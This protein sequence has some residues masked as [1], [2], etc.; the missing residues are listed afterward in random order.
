VLLAKAGVPYALI[1]DLD[2][3]N[4]E[5]PTADVAIVTGANDVVDPAARTDAASPIYG[6]PVLDVDR[7]KNVLVVKRG[8]G[9]GFAGIENDLFHADNANMLFGDVQDVV[10]RLVQGVRV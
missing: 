1:R 8:R 5:F 3:I 7:A 9:T 2:E 6:M 10:A 4:P